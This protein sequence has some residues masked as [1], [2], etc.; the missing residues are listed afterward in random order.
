MRI[1]LIAVALTLAAT[2]SCV[3][4][5]DT[6]HGATAFNHYIGLQANQL[7]KQ[8]LNLSNS[9]AEVNNPYVITYS[10]NSA[11]SGWGGEIG[12][13]FN[14]QSTKN[15]TPISTESK[16]NDLF[17][18]I[19][20]SWKRKIGKRF[21][22]GYGIH[23]MGSSLSDNTTNSNVTLFGNG[24]DSTATT[25]ETKTGTIGFG[26]QLSLA[27]SITEKIFLGT[28]TTFYYS[29]ATEKNNVKVTDYFFDFFNPNNNTI[30]ISNS[31]TEKEI[32]K[33]SLNFPT[34]LFLILKF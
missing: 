11:Y 31:N 15:K 22:G 33:F 12:L 26:P 16:I 34:V 4:Q 30:S 23:I 18:R 1:F 32:S 10:F 27:F 8:I 7:L 20:S 28:E 14:Y 6:T 3:A 24:K 19:G 25:T 13:G 2:C 9:N 21:E 5:R 29:N 17:Y